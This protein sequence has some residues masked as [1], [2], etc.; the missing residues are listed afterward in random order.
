VTGQSPNWYES[1]PK[2]WSVLAR[3]ADPDRRLGPTEV[4]GILCTGQT[5]YSI[6]PTIR[7]ELTGALPPGIGG[8]DVFLHIADSYG[9]AIS[10]NL[11]FGGPGLASVPM[12]DRR[13]IAARGAEVSANF[14]TFEFY[15]RCAQLLKKRG[16]PTVLQPVAPS[17]G[18]CR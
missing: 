18:P 12:N 5:R 17:R 10:H 14:T 7:Y 13:T 1:A 3:I 9:G 15:N 2:N 16:E 8:K 6:G 11:E 4:I